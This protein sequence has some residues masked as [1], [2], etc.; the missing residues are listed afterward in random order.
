MGTAGATRGGSRARK[1]G[2][3]VRC[4]S[5][6]TRIIQPRHAD[7]YSD[8]KPLVSL[9]GK[10]HYYKL[11]DTCSQSPEWVSVYYFLIRFVLL[12]PTRGSIWHGAQAPGDPSQPRPHESHQLLCT[13]KPWARAKVFQCPRKTSR[14]AEA[15]IGF[16]SSAIID[17]Q[18]IGCMLSEW[19]I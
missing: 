12:E 7:G 15:H 5:S 17:A 11:T 14:R 1:K 13:P 16:H 2:R 4:K 3:E 9:P 8:F 18:G 6:K 19:H 10:W